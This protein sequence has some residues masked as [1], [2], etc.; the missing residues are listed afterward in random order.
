MGGVPGMILLAS[1]VCALAFL[2]AATSRRRAWPLWVSLWCWMPALLLMSTRF[3]PRP[4][5]FSLLFTAVLLA[6]L[7][8]VDVRPVWAWA[9][10]V[11]MFFWVNSH[12]LFAIG[13]VVTLGYLFS[14]FVQ[15]IRLGRANSGVT[16]EKRVP[17][18]SHLVP[19]SVLTGIAC[20]ANPYGISG[21]LFPL[22]LLPKITDPSNAYRDSIDEVMSLQ[23]RLQ[24]ESIAGVSGRIYV[25]AQVFLLMILPLSFIFP[26]VW[27]RWKQTNGVRSPRGAVWGG[28][29]SLAA[30]LV[31]IASFGLPGN[32]VPGW[33]VQF[34]RFVPVLLALGGL[35]VSTRLFLKSGGAGV[36]A[37]AGAL[38]C[39][40]WLDWLR[41]YL[42][43]PVN[44][45]ID[46][47]AGAHSYGP[48][49]AGLSIGVLLA[50]LLIRSG[51]DSFRL[52]LSVAF[53]YL[54]LTADRNSSFF[55]LVAGTVL[56]WN[57]SEWVAA[58]HSEVPYRLSRL[59]A[60]M[61]GRIGLALI[62]LAWLF[63]VVTDRF[64]PLT[65]YLLHFG[66][67]ERPLTFAHE[68]ARFAGGD[69]LPDRALVFNLGQT[70]VYI[71]HNAPGRK[72]FMDARLEVPSLATFETY[73]LA[74]TWLNRG[75]PRW[76]ALV[77]RMGEPLIMLDHQS[78]GGA[79]ATLV[80]S[81]SYRCVY[82][83]PTA[84]AFI[85]QARFDLETIYP[86]VNFAERHFAFARGSVLKNTPEED[87]AEARS[88]I[89]LALALSRARQGSA[90]VRLGA[91]LLAQDLARNTLSSR[92]DWSGAWT[93]VGH[94]TKLLY[95]DSTLRPPAPTD[96]WDPAAALPWALSTYSFKRSL[97]TNPNNRSTLRSLSD[98]YKLRG[99]SDAQVEEV[100]RVGA[101]SLT[102]AR[103]MPWPL[104]ERLAIAEMHV[105]DPRTARAI[106][107]RSLDAPS[108][109]LRLA[110]I[111]DASLASFDFQGAETSY[112][113]ALE[114]DPELGEAWYGKALLCLL[115]GKAD[116]VL[117]ACRTGKT[118]P[119][120]EPQLHGLRAF[121]EV[122]AK[123]VTEG[124]IEKA[125]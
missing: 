70:G 119:L 3:D 57:V 123:A 84:S 38:C 30:S 85:P 7:L 1:G 35:S 67:R 71:Y 21:A 87:Y 14:R 80:A 109:A 113:R 125:D 11:V 95:L 32:S 118:L 116:E 27:R 103:G 73:R 34:G 16:D 6:L 74:D 48:M 39:G 60:S 120:S 31:L 43:G 25:I 49:L 101:A 44:S 82:W 63:L 91:S 42:F 124:A 4:E 107:E 8:R 81:T 5:C 65:G 33:L 105:G 121:E 112:R 29:F 111:G 15:S 106:W 12:S 89:E 50:V 75:D 59:I 28:T 72:V 26:A 23:M 58:L 78:N 97:A 17:P 99:I 51:V 22:Q 66:L 104:A 64:F 68:A 53:G 46:W 88:L 115:E 93:L 92:P 117:R 122:A 96:P 36:L 19:A 56:A 79:E 54:G 10:P 102:Q 40:S 114:L 55:G 45:L 61:C 41:S 47:R 18:W 83:D 69:G 24:R 77:R 98:S 62:L 2:I 52:F 37:A 13:I 90:S 94:G 20:L 110:R 86:T 9:L 76:L 100:T 108:E